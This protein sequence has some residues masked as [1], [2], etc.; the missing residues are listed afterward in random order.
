MTTN[1]HQP[2][3]ATGEATAILP[4]PNNQRPVTV[5]GTEAIRATFDSGCIR[6]TINSAMA[7]GVSHMVLN[8]DAHI[9]YGTPVGCVLSSPSHIYPGPSAWISSVR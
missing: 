4:L 1:N 6:Q 3:I 7:P 9:G 2:F 8:P 5:I